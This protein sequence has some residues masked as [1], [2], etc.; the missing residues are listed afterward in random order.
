MKAYSEN[1]LAHTLSKLEDEEKL[2][3]QKTSDENAMKN[4]KGERLMDCMNSA[5]MYECVDLVTE[6]E[7]ERLQ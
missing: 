3:T 5:Q 1:H 4:I 7:V 2:P 6:E